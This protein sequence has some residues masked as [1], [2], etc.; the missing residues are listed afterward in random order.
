MV[1]NHDVL[2][3]VRVKGL[4]IL[5]LESF[6]SWAYAGCLDMVEGAKNH[7]LSNLRTLDLCSLKLNQVEL[8]RQFSLRL[9]S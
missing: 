6:I 4:I 7:P 5:N 1:E 2:L 9:P 8:A 3:A